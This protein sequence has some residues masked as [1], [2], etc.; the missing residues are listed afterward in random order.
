MKNISQ[1]EKLL[2][3]KDLLVESNYS[4]DIQILDIN[5]DS[6]KVDKDTMFIVKGLKFKD[7]YLFDSKE[8]G[9]NSYIAE[10]KYDIDLPSLIVKDIKK[11][12]LEVA[13]L[14]FD[15]PDRKIKLVGITGSKGKSTN[16]YMVKH[17]LDSKLKTEG[18]KPA[19]LV[20]TIRTYDG[21]NEY[22]SHL[23]TPESLDLY[24]NIFN[25]VESGLEYM[26]IEVS[27][28]A[29][30]YD[31]VGKDIDFDIVALL[32]IG[33]DHIGEHEHPT[34][35]DYVNTKL[36][37]FDLSKKIVYYK[38]TDH[39]EEIE[40]ALENKEAVSYDVNNPSSDYNIENINYDKGVNKFTVNGKPFKL[41]MFGDFNIENAAAAIIICKSF[42]MTYEELYQAMETFSLKYRSSVLRTNDGQIVFIVN[43]A[44]DRLSFTRNFEIIKRDFPDYKVVS[45]FGAAGGKGLNR[46]KDLAEVASM[47]SD[48]VY[49][50][51]DDPNFEDPLEIASQI[52]SNFVRDIP[53]EMFN[54]RVLGINKAVEDAK[55]KTVFFLAGKGREDYQLYKGG[56]AKMRSDHDIA[57]ELVEEYNKRNS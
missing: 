14:F 5:F 1:I 7:E 27:S 8:K 34:V 48:K 51:P 44:H 33:H 24:R 2:I 6:R 50:I 9:A 39:I 10:K 21:L 54:K 57:E 16:V 32:N 3:E 12:M 45:L 36:K 56:Y 47:N 29:L 46:R 31:R 28:Q 19:G 11:A 23:T 41:N 49:I 42:G 15:Y 43:Y 17:I 35:E 53:Y 18:K 37:I 40:K 4:E 25:A 30:K 38:S 22:E 26:V 13:R 55:E 20:S 52:A